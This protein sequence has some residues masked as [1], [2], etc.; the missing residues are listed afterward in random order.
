MALAFVTAQLPG[1]IEKYEPAIEENLTKALTTLKES[2]PAN[3][4]LFLDN[5]RKLDTIVE[6]V[7]AAKSAGKKRTRRR[8]T[9]KH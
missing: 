1:L 6:K 9:R 2:D 3:A 5:W 7:M 8:K 4:K